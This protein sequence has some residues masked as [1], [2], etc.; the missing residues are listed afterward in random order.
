VKGNVPKVQEGLKAAALMPE[1]G[2]NEKMQLNRRGSVCG[3]N[4]RSGFPSAVSSLTQDF[5]LRYTLSSIEL[6]Q[7]SWAF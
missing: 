2:T 3:L 7:L 4:R 1:S 5:W 6:E